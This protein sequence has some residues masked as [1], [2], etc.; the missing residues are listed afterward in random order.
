[1]RQA[2]LLAARRGLSLSALLTRVLADLAAPPNLGTGGL[3]TWKR[4]DLHERGT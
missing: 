1:L 3:P 2:R 4:Q